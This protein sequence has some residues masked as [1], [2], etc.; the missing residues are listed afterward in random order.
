MF[1]FEVFEREAEEYI[2]SKRNFLNTV[3]SLMRNVNQLRL[4]PLVIALAWQS[5]DA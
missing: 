4:G 3:G 1:R 5:Q 2:C